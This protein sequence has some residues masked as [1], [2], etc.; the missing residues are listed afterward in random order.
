MRC[1]KCDSDKLSVIETRTDGLSIRRRRECQECTQRFST[2][3]RIEY[4]LPLVIK[5]DNRRENFKASKL[6]DGL[7]KACQK[8]PVGLDK[9]DEVVDEIQKKISESG[10]S[11]IDSKDIGGY[12][13]NGLKN[14]DK[15]A[16]VRFA[17]VYNEFSDIRQFLDTLESL[18][19]KES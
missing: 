2:Y 8:R 12:V 11:E 19:T 13:M 18:K 16:Y 5:K 15:V 10:I 7:I 6:R 3:E 14:L 1:P 9:I 17:S 4:R